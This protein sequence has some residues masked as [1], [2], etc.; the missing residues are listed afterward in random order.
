MQLLG[1]GAQAPQLWGTGLV[2]PLHWD[3]PRPGM[4]PRSPALTD[5][6]FTTGPPGKAY[7]AIYV[8]VY[9]PICWL[10]YFT[11]NYITI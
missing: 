9:L 7:L 5:G 10:V 6:F 11:Y 2:T 3:F 8:N 1:P 4:E